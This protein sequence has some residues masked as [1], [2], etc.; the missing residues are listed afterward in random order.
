MR[1]VTGLSLEQFIA[2]A[3]GL[4]ARNHATFSRQLAAAFQRASVD[5]THGT[6]AASA[7]REAEAAAAT[8]ES[9]QAQFEARAVPAGLS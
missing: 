2:Q 3:L 9:L 4:L 1:D 6:L 5:P 8:F 7:W